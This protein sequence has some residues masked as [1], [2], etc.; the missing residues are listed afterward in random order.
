[1]ENQSVQEY[2]HTTA[3][4][5]VL[6]SA[7]TLR[8]QETNH[9]NH[10]DVS[11][12][13]LNETMEKYLED[14]LI[15]HES[16]KNLEILLKLASEN[17][18][19]KEDLEALLQHLNKL[20]TQRDQYKALL[21]Q[22]ASKL[23]KFDPKN[24]E[25]FGAF[26]EYVRE[27]NGKIEESKSI[28]KE[29]GREISNYIDK[30]NFQIDFLKLKIFEENSLV[31]SQKK[32]EELPTINSRDFS[33]LLPNE[34]ENE[35]ENYNDNEEDLI[36]NNKAGQMSS[37]DIRFPK[38]THPKWTSVDFHMRK[39]TTPAPER[40]DTFLDTSKRSLYEIQARLDYF[41]KR[42]KELEED[43]QKLIQIIN[44]AEP[45][46]PTMHEEVKERLMSNHLQKEDL[47]KML[48]EIQIKQK[49]I[50]E[51]TKDLEMKRKDLETKEQELSQKENLLKSKQSEELP[52]KAP[53]NDNNTLNVENKH[54]TKA[55]LQGSAGNLTDSI[56]KSNRI[57]FKENEALNT[58]KSLPFCSSC[59]IF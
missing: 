33:Q 24:V 18:A 8:H 19:L 32:G 25:S 10:S 52:P 3:N 49:E 45:Q 39:T 47:E 55:S 20:K 9:S 34:N 56:K 21:E 37:R 28:D 11:Y 30:L 15:F 13:V 48:A 31:N 43:N 41:P 26:K 50:E 5:Y 54:Y 51:K 44:N 12:P 36:K 38:K 6:P 46:T 57:S 23:D 40:L 2:S 7:K 1:M 16:D 59:R 58:Q 35:N 14:P 4:Q 17:P 22:M 42:I 53:H 29:Y 27:S